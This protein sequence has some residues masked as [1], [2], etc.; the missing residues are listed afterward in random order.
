MVPDMIAVYH[1]QKNKGTGV[2]ALMWNRQITCSTPPPPFKLLI[3]VQVEAAGA[4]EEG[5]LTLIDRQEV[6]QR[7]GDLRSQ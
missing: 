6:K 5:A 3:T 2:C 1:L 4:V 7:N